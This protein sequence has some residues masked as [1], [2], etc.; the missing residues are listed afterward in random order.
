MEWQH[1]KNA[2][3]WWLGNEESPDATVIEDAI[4]FHY[5]VSGEE[6]PRGFV[7]WTDGKAVLE[8]VE[9]NDDDVYEATLDLAKE[10]AEDGTRV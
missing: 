10:L 2:G 1:D 6:E 4:G 8:G 5:H 7:S 9:S 3:V